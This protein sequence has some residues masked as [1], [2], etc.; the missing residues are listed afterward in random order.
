M[1]LL[2]LLFLYSLPAF[3]FTQEIICR[4]SRTVPYPSVDAC[5]KLIFKL[6]QD[7]WTH[8]S[9]TFGRRRFGYAKVP[10]CWVLGGCQICIDCYPAEQREDRFSLYTYVGSME[11]TVQKCIA[12][13]HGGGVFRLGPRRIFQL[14][15]SGPRPLLQTP[16]SNT[17]KLNDT[18]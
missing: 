9:L 3:I 5:L 10:N 6:E 18:S 13:G 1:R 11:A 16:L 8:I 2:R 17:T 4:D 14:F 15:I 7:D 12:K